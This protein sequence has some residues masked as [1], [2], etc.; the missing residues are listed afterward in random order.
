[1]LFTKIFLST[2]LPPPTDEMAF[3]WTASDPI[4]EF[5]SFNDPIYHPVTLHKK[6]K[7]RSSPEFSPEDRYKSMFWQSYILPSRDENIMLE[8]S[9]RNEFSK[10]GKKFWSV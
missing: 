7:R 9:V 2:F 3:Q 8:H 1:M 4:V 5:F 6:R 10:A